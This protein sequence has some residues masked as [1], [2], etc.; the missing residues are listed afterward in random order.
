VLI[1]DGRDMEYTALRAG[2]IRE[3][4]SYTVAMRRGGEIQMGPGAESAEGPLSMRLYGEREGP[5]RS[6]GVWL[7]EEV[8]ERGVVRKVSL[9]LEVQRFGSLQSMRLPF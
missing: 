4:V 1:R 5:S 3:D 7:W 8:G 9:P 2:R 6:R